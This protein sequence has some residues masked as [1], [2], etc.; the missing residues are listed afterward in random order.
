MVSGSVPL[1]VLSCLV[2]VW[3]PQGVGVSHSL[4]PASLFE[5]LSMGQAR[6]RPTQEDHILCAVRALMPQSAL[7]P[8][9][10]CHRQRDG[11]VSMGSHMQQDMGISQAPPPPRAPTVHTKNL[12]I[13]NWRRFLLR[14]DCSRYVLQRVFN[15]PPGASAGR[16]GGKEAKDDLDKGPLLDGP[17]QRLP[18]QCAKCKFFLQKIRPAGGVSLSLQARFWAPRSLAGEALAPHQESIISRNCVTFS[19]R[20]HSHQII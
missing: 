16:R 10:V 18:F 4:L 11:A 20:H 13:K 12:N 19:K 7:F 5:H 2:P 3:S 6:S 9:H 15:A 17:A 14:Q 8:P 1:N